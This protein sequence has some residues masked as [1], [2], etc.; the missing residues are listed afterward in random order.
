MSL[1][2]VSAA[3]VAKIFE[4][5]AAVLTGRWFVI[6]LHLSSPGIRFGFIRLISRSLKLSLVLASFFVN[7]FATIVSPRSTDHAAPVPLSRPA[8]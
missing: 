8:T 2:T 5:L 7:V 6:A 1:V 3:N 4:F